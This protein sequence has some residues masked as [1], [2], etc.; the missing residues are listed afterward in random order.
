[1]LK[2]FVITAWWP[3]THNILDSYA[4][5][6]FSHL[7]GGN[8]AYGCQLNGS[9]PSPATANEAFECIASALPYIER[10]G[11][12]FIFYLGNY[13][14]TGLPSETILGGTAA[15]GGVT[16]NSRFQSPGY[17]TAPEIQ[18]LLGQ[19][20]TRNLSHIVEAIELHD[21]IT[22][23]MGATAAAASYLRDHAPHVLPMGNAGYGGATSLYETRM[24]IASPE[25]YAI[26][27][28]TENATEAV[29]LQLS[30]YAINQYAGDKFRIDT[31]PLFYLGDNAKRV[32][33]SPSLVR[34]QVYGSLAYG[35]RGL[36]YYCWG[37]GIWKLP[38]AAA[39]DGGQFAGRG[40][41][42]I[43]YET[44]KR[45][46]AD[47][48]VWGTILLDAKHVGAMRT[49]QSTA[50]VDF[51]ASPAADL[52]VIASD[53]S[54]LIGAFITPA[55]GELRSGPKEGV[56]GYL[57]VVDLRTSPNDTETP[58]L[59]RRAS[60]TLHSACAGRVI[61]G[62]KGGW[63]EAAMREMA[64][65]DV[66]TPLV[67]EAKGNMRL[68]LPGGGGAL[69]ELRETGSEASP[70]GGV[71]DLGGGGDKAVQSSTCRDVLVRVRR[72]W[73]DPRRL[74]LRPPDRGTR[75]DA[76]ITPKDATFNRYG[77]A[78]RHFSPG[79][80]AGY[81]SDFIIGGSNGESEGGWGSPSEAKAW[82]TAGFNVVSLTFTNLTHLRTSL[83]H[84]MAFGLFAIAS[85]YP[86][87]TTRGKSGSLTPEAAGKL[88]TSLSCHPN[89][90]GLE[91]SARG[92]GTG[93]TASQAEPPEPIPAIISEVTEVI[94]AEG[95][96][97]VPFISR[98]PSIA[99]AIEVARV[100]VPLAPVA[101][102]AAPVAGRSA[103]ENVTTPGRWARALVAQVYAHARVA[104]NLSMPPLT[105]AAS[106]DVC[107]LAASD[108]MLRFASY[109]SILYGAQAIF[110]DGVGRCA[111]PGS[112][113]F[114][115]LGAVNRRLAQW[116]GPLFLQPQTY[117]V[118]PWRVTEVYSTAAWELPPLQGVAARKPGTFPS[119][120]VQSLGSEMVAIT[121]ENRTAAAS[122]SYHNAR[123]LLF[124]FS[125]ELSVVRGGAGVRQ[126]PVHLR[127]D[128]VATRPLEPDAYQGFADLPGN[129]APPP[130]LPPTFHGVQGCE[131]QWVGNVLTQL[132]LPGGGMQLVSYTIT[133]DWQGQMN[134]GGGTEEIAT[135]DAS[136]ASGRKGR[137]PPQ[138]LNAV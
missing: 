41:P 17:L 11:L 101:L 61:A 54:L 44:V 96:W 10:L 138:R 118:A 48:R 15:F 64:Q 106:L 27:H 122:R 109:A 59:P 12:K 111:R 66:E 34:V 50:L 77:A 93:S 70:A 91:V 38:T 75:T 114:T 79:G 25:E 31:W 135:Q 58:I 51:S 110:W 76:P 6:G 14:T 133:E 82:A 89:L 72:W 119:D 35:A 68:S 4:S 32:V 104:A 121:L 5:A 130:T 9:I 125:T 69:I 136:R 53:E 124:F 62:G 113:A 127:S 7:L 37:N 92:G 8:E 22:T 97:L 83:A 74:S 56:A 30:W 73:F 18:W 19:L 24:P 87:K 2:R 67:Q 42:T 36:F 43:N 105:M 123:R 120:L 103:S 55:V 112:D 99:A 86:Q 132:R 29:D 117:R 129:E 88:Y 98:V 100:G 116:A 16:D 13:N 1:M 80:L 107:R 84:A 49:P 65:V 134:R 3:P 47:A 131:L 128:V 21:D 26:A 60:L 40:E 45:M 115:L 137:A 95:Y 46:N 71:H 102:P 52:P 39:A 23:V 108:S 85:A 78:Q 94:R 33:T 126:I 90:M 28:D 63:A 20:R 57:M 81:K